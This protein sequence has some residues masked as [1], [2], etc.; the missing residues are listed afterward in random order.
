MQKLCVKA[1]NFAVNICKKRILNY[2]GFTNP[3][4]QLQNLGFLQ[5]AKII[6]TLF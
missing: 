1:G 5:L 3:N 4:I 6:L 2:Q